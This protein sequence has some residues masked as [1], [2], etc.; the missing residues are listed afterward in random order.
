MSRAKRLLELMDR[1]RGAAET[2]VPALAR[3]LGTSTRTLRRD[4]AILRE[5]G[6][7]IT[8]DA[9]RG[10]GIRLE[11]QRGV[12]AVHLAI[13]EVVALWLAARLSQATAEVP[14]SRRAD[15]ALAKLLAS[16]PRARARDLRELCGRIFIGPPAS[17]AVRATV[18][19][20]PAE[21][22]RLFEEA[23][24]MGVA[25]GFEYRDRS[26]RVSTRRVEPHGLLISTPVWYI[27]ARDVDFG[28]PRSFRMDRVAR[29]TLL[30]TLH[31]RPDLDVVRAQLPEG[32]PWEP[33]LAGGGTR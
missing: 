10:G 11:G 25:L 21:L 23:V 28:A 3:D 19:D 4:L 1:L 31:F 30:R 20:G 2:T 5:R 7:P 6:M 32:V 27:L 16:L 24:A 15:S 12:T 13:P 22:L 26:A 9:G 14:W 17:P 18:T 33:L 8:G 29:P